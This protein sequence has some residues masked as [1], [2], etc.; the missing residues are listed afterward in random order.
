[1]NK[2]EKLFKKSTQKEYT[3]LIMHMM[4][5][6]S[7]GKELLKM[8]IETGFINF[9]KYKL[10]QAKNNLIFKKSIEKYSKEIRVLLKCCLSQMPK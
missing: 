1:M 8:I 4:T 5:I 7:L 2:V 9:W 3:N 10:L 6:G